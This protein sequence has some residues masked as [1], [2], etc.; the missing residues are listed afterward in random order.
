MNDELCFGSTVYP[1]M[2]GIL[3][4]EL[5]ADSLSDNGCDSIEDIEEL[6]LTVTLRDENYNTLAEPVITLQFS[7]EN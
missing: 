6:E 2:S 3:D 4:V 7:G 1:G 5:S